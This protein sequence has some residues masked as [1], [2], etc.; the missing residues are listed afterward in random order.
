M[1]SYFW[2]W[3]K[4]ADLVLWL[5]S[6]V[7]GTSE[8][9][10]KECTIEG[11]GLDALLSEKRASVHLFFCFTSLS[12]EAGPYL[13]GHFEKQWDTSARGVIGEM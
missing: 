7:H 13:V 11:R 3:K 6:M 4:A 5:G 10:P 9:Q 2:V 8:Q 1:P 12:E